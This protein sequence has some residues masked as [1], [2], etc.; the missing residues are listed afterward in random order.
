MTDWK[1]FCIV[2]FVFVSPS[3]FL[4]L[5][6]SSSSSLFLF[7]F[8]DTLWL[9]L[10]LWLWLWPWL[11]LWF[12]YKEKEVRSRVMK[13]VTNFLPQPSIK[14]PPNNLLIHRPILHRILTFFPSK[15]LLHSIKRFVNIVFLLVTCCSSSSSIV[16]V[17]SRPGVEVVGSVYFGLGWIRWEVTC[18]LVGRWRVG[19]VMGLVCVL[20]FDGGWGDCG[21]DGKVVEWGWFDR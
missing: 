4:F 16:A 6:S 8:L 14:P 17:G 5:Y 15:L 7:L 19:Y 18:K 20:C 10:W 11:W 13:K 1:V 12:N 2:W 9:C 3:P 21:C